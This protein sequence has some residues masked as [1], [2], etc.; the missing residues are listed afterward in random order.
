MDQR[1]TLRAHLEAVRVAD[2]AR[3][4][5]WAVIEAIAAAAIEL[6]ALIA[7]GPLAGHHRTGRRHQLRRRSA[8]GY[9]YRRR[10]HDAARPARYRRGGGA[11]RRGGTAGDAVIPRRRSASRS[12]RSTDRPTAK[13]TSPSARF[14]PSVRSGSDVIST[15]FEPGTAQCAAGFIVYG[16]QTTLVLALDGRVDIFI[17]DPATPRSSC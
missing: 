4:C 9:R 17:L 15:F 8:K 2:A 13:T 14:F 11:F 3:R 7:A 5:T 1:V 10:R 12:T 16:P 6:A